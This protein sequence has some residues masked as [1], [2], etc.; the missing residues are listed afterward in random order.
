LRRLGSNRRRDAQ[1]TTKATA[2]V[3]GKGS[4]NASIPVPAA[5]RYAAS[6]PFAE[7]AVVI[8]AAPRE[9]VFAFIDDPARVAGHMSK[10]SWPMAGATMQVRTDVGRGR[11]PGS[12]T[13]LAG[14][15][16]GISLFV[17]TEVLQRDPPY[18]KSWG[19][20]APARLLVIGDYRISVRLD[21][22][23]GG[24][25]VTI[26]I[27]YAPPIQHASIVSRWAARA[28]AR[29]CVRRIATDVAAAFACTAQHDDTRGH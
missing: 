6:L 9:K 28:Y 14:R 25:H 3:D 2:T 21:R 1:A 20:S 4:V 29:W 10:A 27:D 11:Q 7:E 22:V 8:V 23:P 26:R 5:D 24:S 13:R 18:F 15:V 12:R 19:T 16:L 17:E